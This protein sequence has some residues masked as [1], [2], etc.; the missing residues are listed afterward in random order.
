[1]TIESAINKQK[2]KLINKAKQSGLYEDFGQKEISMLENKFLT[3]DF[4][5]DKKTS[6]S[7]QTFNDWCMNYTKH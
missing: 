3:G 2:A 7:I 4:H 6:Q 1:M 5:V